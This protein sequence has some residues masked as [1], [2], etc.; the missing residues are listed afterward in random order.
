[1]APGSGLAASAAM[2]SRL[3]RCLY[4]YCAVL[5]AEFED[6]RHQWIIDS[7]WPGSGNWKLVGRKIGGSLWFSPPV[8]DL[9]GRSD[10]SRSYSLA[11]NTYVVWKPGDALCLWIGWRD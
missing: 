3:L 8:T 2:V 5:A 7:L 10:D 1:A 6:R 4:I 9:C 11:N